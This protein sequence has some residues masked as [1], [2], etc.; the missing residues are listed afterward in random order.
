MPSHPTRWKINPSTITGLFDFL[1]DH[2]NPI[3]FKLGLVSDILGSLQWRVK[4]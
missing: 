1:L 4:V 3:D 2:L